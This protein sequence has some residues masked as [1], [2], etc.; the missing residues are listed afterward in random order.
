[1]SEIL[2]L[3]E[4]DASTLVLRVLAVVDDEAVLVPSLG[5]YMVEVLTTAE[6]HVSLLFSEVWAQEEEEAEKLVDS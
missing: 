1:M 2:K 4:N 5:P 6:G 3:V